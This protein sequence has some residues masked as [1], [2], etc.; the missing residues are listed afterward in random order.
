MSSSISSNKYESLPFH[1]HFVKVMN[2]CGCKRI[3]LPVSEDLSVKFKEREKEIKITELGKKKA[4]NFL[5]ILLCG[6]RLA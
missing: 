2:I 4:I 5:V 3:G 1:F 6:Y